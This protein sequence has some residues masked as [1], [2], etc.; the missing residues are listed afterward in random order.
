[1]QHSIANN[2]LG[3]PLQQQTPATTVINLF[4]TMPIINIISCNEILIHCHKLD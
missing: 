2:L 1:M 4:K 3:T